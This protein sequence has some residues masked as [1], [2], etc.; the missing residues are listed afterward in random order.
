MKQEAPITSTKS[1][2]LTQA[3]I[4]Q[5]KQEGASMAGLNS[6]SSSWG[7]SWGFG[8][9]NNQTNQYGMQNQ[10]N[11]Y[12]NNQY[13]QYN[14]YGQNNAYGQQQQSGRFLSWF[15]L[16][17]NNQNAQGQATG[18]WFGQNRNATGSNLNQF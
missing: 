4:N 9:T 16:G 14:Q 18:G 6:T 8:G 1:T 5:L 13:N 12:G 2:P 10:T 3:Q 17:G 15:G 11:Q 7:S